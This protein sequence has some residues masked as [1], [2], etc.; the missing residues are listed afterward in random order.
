[1]P[2]T[3]PLAITGPGSVYLL[4]I[5]GFLALVMVTL[6]ITLVEGVALTLLK[7][8]HFRA[9]IIVSLI[10]NVASGIINGALLILLQ[11]SPL[12]WLPISFV[13]SLLIEGIVLMY[14]KRDAARQN[15]LFVLIVN[16]A[17]YVMLI[18]PAY[19]YG[20]RA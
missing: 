3:N 1:L 9:S 2:T 5:F 15:W 6:L 4:V 10:M 7:W 16:L 17:S 14:F 12:Q 8:N 19:Y 13:L 20:T 18:L 11:H